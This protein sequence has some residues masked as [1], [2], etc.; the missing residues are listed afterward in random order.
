MAL[1]RGAESKKVRQPFAG[2]GDPVFSAGGGT[3]A[4]RASARNLALAKAR[5]ATE[6]R[7]KAVAQRGRPRRSA[8]A[9]SSPWPNGVRVAVLVSVLPEAWAKGNSPGYFPRARP[10]KAGQFELRLANRLE[11]RALNFL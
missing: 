8:N 7:L 11:R 6:D 2:F 9:S 5:N 4:T 3:A 10:L 1:R